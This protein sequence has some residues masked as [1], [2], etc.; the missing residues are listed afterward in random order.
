M[1]KQI[2]YGVAAASIRQSPMIR[3]EDAMLEAKRAANRAK[4]NNQFELLRTE[5][6]LQCLHNITKQS[7]QAWDIDHTFKV[8]GK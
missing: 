5:Q 6:G 2:N 3:P 1:I 8:G 7:M 4:Q